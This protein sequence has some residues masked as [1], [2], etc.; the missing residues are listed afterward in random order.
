MESR[1]GNWSILVTVVCQGQYVGSWVIRGA[2]AGPGPPV[3]VMAPHPGALGHH[4]APLGPPE[5]AKVTVYPDYLGLTPTLWRLNTLPLPNFGPERAHGC[6]TVSL[7]PQNPE[8]S[9]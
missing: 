4:Q 8:H 2:E 6:G 1:P 3:P 5:A 9:L 7:E